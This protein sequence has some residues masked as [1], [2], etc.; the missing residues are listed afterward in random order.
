MARVDRREKLALDESYRY[1]RELEKAG[2]QPDLY[3][4][5]HCFKTVSAAL[6]IADNGNFKLT[7]QL[8]K[9]IH[10]AL[11]DKLVTSFPGYLMVVDENGR[12]L[13]PKSKFPEDGWVEYHPDGCRRK[14]DIFRLEIKHLYPG[15]HHCMGKAWQSKGARLS[16]EDFSG[17]QCSN[18]GCFLKPVVLGDEVLRQESD[19]GRQKAYRDW[20]DLYQQAY[21]T[22]DDSEKHLIY[23]RMDELES[24]WGNL[25]Y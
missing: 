4:L 24:V 16:P 7:R 20:W 13:E 1:Y 14:D 12:Q 18:A 21:C 19:S 10:Q 11:F 17:P 2:A 6:N 9:R 8:W 3:R 22:R 23:R 25:Y 5:V 15:T